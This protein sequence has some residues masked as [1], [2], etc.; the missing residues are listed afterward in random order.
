MAQGA[1]VCKTG[2]TEAGQAM[3][4]SPAP[5]RMAAMAHIAAAPA[6]PRLP[7]TIST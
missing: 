2:A 4:V 5:A 6:I 1:N 3:V 7:A